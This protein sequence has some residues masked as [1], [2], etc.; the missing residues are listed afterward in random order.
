MTL[1]RSDIADRIIKKNGVPKQLALEFVDAFFENISHSLEQGEECKFTGFGN[2]TLRLK[3]P[4]PG[5][6]PKT[7]EE[8]EISARRVTTFKIGQKMKERVCK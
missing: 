6:N 5:R 7:G 4:R 3:N 1:T 2:F 8:V